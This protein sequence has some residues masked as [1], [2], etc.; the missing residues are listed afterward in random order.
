MTDIGVAT[1][2]ATLGRQS[3]DQYE[4][5]I[6]AAAADRIANKARRLGQAHVIHVNST[7][8]GGGVAEILTP[9]TLMMNALGIATGW[10]QI[11][12]TPAFFDCTKKFHNALQGEKVAISAAEKAVYEQVVFEN[13][14]RLHLDGCDAVVIHDPQP[15][16]LVTNFASRRMP[17]F[18]QCHID[19]ST[20][21]LAAWNYL[22]TFVERHDAA[23][24]SL[25]EYA[26]DLSVEQRFVAP[27]INPFSA[28][29]RE[30]SRQEISECLV[31]HRIPTDRPLVTQISRFDRWK[32]PLGVIEACRLARQE[33]DCTL[34]LLGNAATDDPE[35][36]VVLET[37]LNSADERVIVITVDDPV[38]VNALQRAS[39]VVLQKSTREGFGLTVTEAMWK[40]AVVIGGDVGGIRRQITDGESGFLVRTPAEAA[41]RIVQVLRDPDIRHR[42]GSRAQQTVRENFLMSRLVEDWLDLLAAQRKPQGV[43]A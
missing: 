20:P 10:R 27:A 38:L 14:T 8:Y 5:L 18:W 32:D 4:P 35:G 12:G 13:A 40:G 34:V 25:P 15:L 1:E 37:I 16:P 24:F 42:L 2:K 22:R 9:L 33:V 17:W 11:Q 23:L 26:K 21:D 31:R 43:R 3:I 41:E 39:A 30:L 36:K 29:N 7:F 6:G 19:V 28:K